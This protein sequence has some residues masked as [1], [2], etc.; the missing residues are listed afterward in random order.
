MDGIGHGTWGHGVVDVGR[1]DWDD[2][3]SELLEV[4]VAFVGQELS[5]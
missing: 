4:S 1:H 2:F 3:D 5:H